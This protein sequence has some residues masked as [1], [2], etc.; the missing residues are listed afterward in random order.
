MGARG[1][2]RIVEGGFAAFCP[3]CEGY[4]SFDSRWEFNWDFDK[5]TFSPS[6]L[7]NGSDPESRCHSFVR[8][9]AWI[10][11]E[12]SCHGLRGQRVEMETEDD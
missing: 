8:D 7:V 2:L 5:P 6:L 12:D 3:G 11:L 1:K 9:G 4:H 10:F